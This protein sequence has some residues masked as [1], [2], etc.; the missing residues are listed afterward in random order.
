MKLSKYKI[1][2]WVVLYSPIKNDKKKTGKGQET[3]FGFI[4]KINITH[5]NNQYFVQMLSSKDNENTNWEYQ[6]SDGTFIRAR[7]YYNVKVK[8]K[9]IIRKI[10]KFKELNEKELKELRNTINIAKIKEVSRKQE[11]NN[12]L[13]FE[14]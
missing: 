1:G 5:N 8:E 11:K 6:R 10:N 3:R 12:T 7:N 14:M 2:E 4:Y 13:E 9:Y